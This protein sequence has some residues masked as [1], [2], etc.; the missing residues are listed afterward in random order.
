MTELLLIQSF[1]DYLKFEKRYSQHTVRSYHDDLIQCF[2]YLELQFGKLEL[3]EIKA[4]FIRSWLASLKDANLSSKT[5]NRKISTL[6]SFFKYHV[7]LGHLPQTPMATI[8]SPKQS[9]RLPQFVEQKDIET[10]FERVE[11]SVGW[12]GRTERLAIKIFYHTGMRLSELIGLKESQVDYHNQGIRVLGKGNKERIIPVSREL[13]EDMKR[14]VE[15][16]AEN[17]FEPGTWLLLTDKGKPLYSRY[18]YQVVRDTLQLVT[19][20]DKKSPHVLRHSFATHLMNNGADLNSVKELLGH[21]SLAST[22]IY[23]HNTIEKLKEVYKK[24]HPKA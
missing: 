14:Y 15:E 8:I 3:A 9:R 10:L 24:A 6:K 17:K 7:R 20:I 13:L 22:Q 16:K 23:T 1:V 4:P 21:A 19:T 18:L 2:D 11:F 12:K 5:I